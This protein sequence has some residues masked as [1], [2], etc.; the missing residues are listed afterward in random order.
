MPIRS[1]DMAGVLVLKKSAGLMM[2]EP[3]HH[4]RRQAQAPIAKAPPLVAPR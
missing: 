1:A 2:P 3:R 4:G